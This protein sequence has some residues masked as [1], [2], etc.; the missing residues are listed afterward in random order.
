MKAIRLTV[1]VSL[2]GVIT[3]S[4]VEAFVREGDNIVLEQ[5]VQFTL[6]PRER[7]IIRPTGGKKK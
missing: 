3:G 1:Q 2:N 5:D 7:P 6:V 4:P